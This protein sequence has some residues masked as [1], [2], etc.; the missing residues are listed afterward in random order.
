LY[1]CDGILAIASIF[2]VTAA[3]TAPAASAVTSAIAYIHEAH[4]ATVKALKATIHKVKTGQLKLEKIYNEGQ[5]MI[6]KIQRTRNGL[7]AR[8]REEL[9][10]R[11]NTPRSQDR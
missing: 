6:Q 10:S 3:F 7:L 5:Q 2:V 1:I 11:A 9:I 8:A 4:A